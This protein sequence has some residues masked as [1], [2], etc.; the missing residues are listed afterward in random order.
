MAN[1]AN[2]DISKKLAAGFALI[3]VLIIGTVAIT[4]NGINNADEVNKRV[5]KLRLPTVLASTEMT[6]GINYSLAALRGWMILGKDK[7]KEDRVKAWNNIDTSFMKMKEFSKNWTNPENIKRLQE[8]ETSLLRFK[9]A[10]QEI[11]TISGTVGNTPATKMLVEQAAPKAKIIITQITKMINI[12]AKLAATPER[13]ALLGMM[14]DVRGSMGLSLANIRAFLLTGDKKFHNEFNRFWETNERRFSD[15]FDNRHLLNKEQALSLNMFKDARDTFKGLPPKMFDI[16]GGQQWNMANYW[17]GTKAAPEAGI[18]MKSLNTMVANQNKLAESDL[19]IAD[20]TASSLISLIIMLGVISTVLAIL[21]TLYIVRMISKPLQEIIDISKPLSEGDLT[22]RFIESGDNEIGRMSV[23]LNDFVDKIQKVMLDVNSSVLNISS[24]SE[25]ISATA[26]SLSQGAT[27]Q[28]ASI[29]ETSASL[30]QMGASINQNSDNAKTTDSVASKSSSDAQEGGEAVVET[31]AAMKSIADKISIIEDIAY[32]TNLLALNAAIEAA[33]AGEHGKGFAVV[34]AEV[35]KLAER[36]QDSAQDI[37]EL[38]SNSVM[39]AER[40]GG[41]LTKIVPSIQKTADLVQEISA[42]SEEQA[43]GVGQVMIAVSQLDKVA[44]T[45]A[46]AS[47]E[48]AAT[49]EEL[50]AQANQLQDVVSFFTLDTS[51]TTEM[52]SKVID[53]SSHRPRENS[54]PVYRTKS[55]ITDVDFERF[56]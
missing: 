39:V 37:S 38:A 4:Y 28:A 44:Q 25:E 41:L 5:I 6:N 33:R 53:I 19:V 30:E 43:S 50:S 14:A 46:S 26:Q 1:L 17:L 8:I 47:E 51:S 49:S 20:D 55:E 27:E 42:A 13:K 35:R 9:K 12:E 48:L 31:V 56:S 32:K 29:E 10:Q 11:E 3:T 2:I 15:L 24:G 23:S 34:A 21:I 40:A 16:R 52:K 45:N 36:S 18:I 7:F 22:Q 54:P